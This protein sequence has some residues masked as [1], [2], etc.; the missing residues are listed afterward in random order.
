[1]LRRAAAGGGGI[2]CRMAGK[3]IAGCPAV[4]RVFLGAF[5][6]ARPNCADAREI[7]VRAENVTHEN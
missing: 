5:H 6:F 3:S 7:F 2:R 4:E 1:M